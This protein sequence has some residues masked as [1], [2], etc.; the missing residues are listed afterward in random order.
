MLELLGAVELVDGF[1]AL[2]GLR[3]LDA[4]DRQ[5]AR[6]RCLRWGVGI[7]F[8]ACAIVGAANSIAETNATSE[9]GGARQVR[10]T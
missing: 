5:R 3:E 6:G 8:S 9:V 1:V 4:V 2:L 7:A 10:K